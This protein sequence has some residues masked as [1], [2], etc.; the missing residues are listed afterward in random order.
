[1]ELFAT[2]GEVRQLVLEQRNPSLLFSFEDNASLAVCSHSLY[3]VTDLGFAEV[4]LAQ[5]LGLLCGVSVLL[6]RIGCSGCVH[7][8]LLVL[9]FL[10]TAGECVH[11]LVMT[12]LSLRLG[13]TQLLSTLCLLGQR[14]TV[15]LLKSLLLLLQMKVLLLSLNCLEPLSFL[16]LQLTHRVMNGSLLNLG[17]H[18]SRLRW[19][20]RILHN[21]VSARMM[22]WNGLESCLRRQVRPRLVLVLMIGLVHRRQL[23]QHWSARHR[24]I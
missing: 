8:I 3:D 11:L 14:I 2:R 13:L 15:L 17:Q 22:Q 7:F 5:Q 21:S 6:V 12:S 4:N 1:M 9:Q 20:H 19:L 10:T 16:S 23:L 18:H 24:R